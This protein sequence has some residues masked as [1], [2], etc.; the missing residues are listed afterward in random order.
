M[1]APSTEGILPSGMGRWLRRILA[2]AAAECLVPILIAA[3]AL[4]VGAVRSYVEDSVAAAPLVMGAT[5]I[6]AGMALGITLLVGRSQIR[7]DTIRPRPFHRIGIVMIVL[8]T[9]LILSGVVGTLLA[10][11]ALRGA[12]D[13]LFAGG[14]LLITGTIGLIS[15][16]VIVS[17]SHRILSTTKERNE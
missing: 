3:S 10:M 9:G 13:A 2:V 12:L 14:S 4:F 11:F 15:G 8:S 6:Y 7:G 17:S 5:G 16:A 1:C